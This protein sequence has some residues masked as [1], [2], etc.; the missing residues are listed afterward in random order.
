LVSAQFDLISYAHV[1]KELNIVANF[2]SKEGQNLEEGKLNLM[3][4]HD[5]IKFL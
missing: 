3:E 2:L 5:G 1:F 4:I